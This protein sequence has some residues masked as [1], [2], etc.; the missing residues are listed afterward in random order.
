MTY[1]LAF[2]LAILILVFFHE[3]GHFLVARWCGVKVLTFSIGFGPKLCSFKDKKGTEFRIAAFPLGGYVRMLGEDEFAERPTIAE[4][5]QSFKY[6]SPTRKIAIAGAGP[7]ASLLL[8]LAAFYIILITGTRELDPYIGEV[9]DTSI[10]A[11]H[12]IESGERILSIDGDTTPTW[13]EVNFA[14]VERL[15]D[16]GVIEIETNKRTYALPITSWL[17]NQVDPFPIQ[18]LGLTPAV[19]PSIVLIESGSPAERAG[20]AVGDHIA[21]INGEAMNSWA[22]VVSAIRKSADVPITLSVERGLATISLVLVPELIVDDDGT[23]FGRAGIQPE[24]GRSVRYGPIEAIPK[25]ISRTTDFIAI[26]AVSM[27]KMV[28]GEVDVRN[29]GG[30]VRIA[31]YAGDFARMGFEPYLLLLAALTI[32]LGLINLLPIP[33]LDGGHILFGLIELVIRREVPAKAQ[34]IGMRIGILVIGSLMIFALYNDIS[35]LVA[36]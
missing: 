7:L 20:L 16:T 24:I 6:Q 15:G 33:M 31:E 26:T 10:A 12:G 14:L 34:A 28:R 23:T 25:A 11:Q 35:L 3:L 2:C 29:L 5:K 32:A 9:A 19:R 13:D 18:D 17:S 22:D 21:A 1:I 30:P 36:S 8:G 4:V 27:Y